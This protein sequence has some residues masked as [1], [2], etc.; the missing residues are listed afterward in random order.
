MRD[1][2]F[3]LP[4]VSHRTCT[5]RYDHSPSNGSLRIKK[6]RRNNTRQDERKNERKRGRTRKS[7]GRTTEKPS[8]KQ[9]GFST[10][11]CVRMQIPI[12]FAA[13]RH[14]FVTHSRPYT[15]ADSMVH[16][17]VAVSTRRA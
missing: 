15:V 9:C 7:L 3:D 12:C 4:L 1:I 14:L 13:G 16:T 17:R 5:Q 6:G 11:L 10:T 8:I 2:F